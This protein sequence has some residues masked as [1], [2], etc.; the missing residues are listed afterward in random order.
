V[1]KEI[2]EKNLYKKCKTAVGDKTN[3]SNSWG[4]LDT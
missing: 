1:K 2:R 3:G 4:M